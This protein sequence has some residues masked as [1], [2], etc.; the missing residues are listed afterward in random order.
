MREF[1]LNN[2]NTSPSCSIS[3]S[4]LNTIEKAGASSPSTGP[5]RHSFDRAALKTAPQ[6]RRNAVSFQDLTQEIVDPQ[7]F[8]FKEKKLNLKMIAKNISCS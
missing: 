8:M 1:N 6:L 4:G 5:Y 3:K 7:K 2:G